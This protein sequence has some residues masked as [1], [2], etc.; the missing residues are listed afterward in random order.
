[1]QKSHQLFTQFFINAGP[2]KLREISS[3]VVHDFSS[4]PDQ[5][6]VPRFRRLFHTIFHE[7]GSKRTCR[8]RIDFLTQFSLNSSGQPILSGHFPAVAVDQVNVLTQSFLNSGAKTTVASDDEFNSERRFRGDRSVDTRFKTVQG[9]I[10]GFPKG[11]RRL[12]G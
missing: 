6:D 5:T 8:D 7:F 10:R 12:R 3:I 11:S 2:N 4:I 1:L 9:V